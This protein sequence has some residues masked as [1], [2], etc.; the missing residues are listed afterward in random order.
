MK[1]CANHY[2]VAVDLGA[3][4]GKMAAASFDG[5]RIELADYITFP[6]QP[7]Q[8]LDT[9]YWDVFA[10][11]RSIVSG[12]T[13]Y[14]SELGPAATI[15]IDTWGASYGL[16]DK[17]GRLLEPVYH[18]RDKRTDTIMDVIYEKVSQRR[19]FELTGVQ[20]NRTYT[21][22]QLY[23]CIVNGDT[24]LDNADK[25]LFLPDLLG[26]FISG[27]MSTEM[28]IAGT[29]ALMEPSQENWSKQLFQ[30][31]SI[32][33]HFL[34]NLVDAGTVKGTV[35][36]EIASLTGIGPAKLPFPDS[37]K[38]SCTSALAPRSAW[39]SKLTSLWY[40]RPLI[41]AALR[42]PAASPAER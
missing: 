35:T 4:G 33:T 3:S 9:L 17:K 25:L 38:T 15:G 36:P 20:F 11:Y 29:S 6:N 40:L 1:K 12:M 31:F 27:Q 7:V 16:L 10:L 28:T 22:P 34:T 42:T 41:R 23:S 39:E 5:S 37:A 8:I 26:Y 19:I 30:E 32:P 21:L 18:Y 14:A 2:A 13:Q 24:C